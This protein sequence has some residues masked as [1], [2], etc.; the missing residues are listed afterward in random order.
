MD[1]FLLLLV[2]WLLGLVDFC[3]CSWSYIWGV[4]PLAALL[5]CTLAFVDCYLES[6]SALFTLRKLYTHTAIL[7]CTW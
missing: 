5:D 2:L 4:E 6:F 1:R 7:Q 3:S